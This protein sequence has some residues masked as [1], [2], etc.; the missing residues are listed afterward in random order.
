MLTLATDIFDD[1]AVVL[2]EH[3]RSALACCR[4]RW[5]AAAGMAPSWFN[6]NSKA[7]AFSFHLRGHCRRR[8]RQKRFDARW[9]LAYGNLWLRG[10]T[11]AARGSAPA[12]D[13]PFHF[14]EEFVSP[15]FDAG[16]APPLSDSSGKVLSLRTR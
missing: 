1:D 5:A 6:L 14:S 16:S 2:N 12:S 7:A 9:H 8:G 13:Y 11:P 10:I 15:C 3:G 4:S